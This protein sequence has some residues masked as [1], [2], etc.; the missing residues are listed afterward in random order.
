MESSFAHKLAG[1]RSRELIKCLAKELLKTWT[2]LDANEPNE[3]FGLPLEVHTVIY[4][5]KAPG[6]GMRVPNLDS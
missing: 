5:L 3:E 4:I 1:S 6:L 2:K